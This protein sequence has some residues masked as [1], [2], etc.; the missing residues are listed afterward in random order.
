[1]RADQYQS[2]TDQAGNCHR[3]A[4]ENKTAYHI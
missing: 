2:F 4:K 3:K 1:M